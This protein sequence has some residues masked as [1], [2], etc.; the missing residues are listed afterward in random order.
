[1]LNTV[2]IL[3]FFTKLIKGT[4]CVFVCVTNLIAPHYITH[5]DQVRKISCG[6]IWYTCSAG[7]S[8][9]LAKSSVT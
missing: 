5:C 2:T 9:F 8:K 7:F 1:M 6:K 4:C 3:K